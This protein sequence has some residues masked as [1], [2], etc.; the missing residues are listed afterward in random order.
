MTDRTPKKK[1]GVV[2]KFTETQMAKAIVVGDGL[3]RSVAKHLKCSR[4]T[5]YEYIKRYPALAESV[6]SARED[7]L[8]E[9]ESELMKLIREGHPAA[10]FFFLKTQGK[11]RG[12]VERQ[13]VDVAAGV[14]FTLNIGDRGQDDG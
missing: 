11:S 2:L 13:E 8:D 7:A 10:I 12:Y 1:C 4:N 5:V 14:K 9:A 3:I 6:A